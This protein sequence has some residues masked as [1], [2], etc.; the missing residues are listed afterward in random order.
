[1]FVTLDSE[2]E[3]EHAQWL[4]WMRSKIYFE[5]ESKLL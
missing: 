3:H 2:H 1:M 4:S 5:I